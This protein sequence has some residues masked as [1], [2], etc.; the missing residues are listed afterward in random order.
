MS[1]SIVEDGHI[2]SPGGYRA[3]GVSA[4]LKEIRARDLA[5][6]YSLQPCRAAALFT[7]NVMSAASVYLSQAVLSRNRE[8]IRAVLIN[9]G[10]ANAGTGPQG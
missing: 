4:G 6:V 7:T 1:Y 8:Q 5:L 9:A 3:T 10:H 2:S